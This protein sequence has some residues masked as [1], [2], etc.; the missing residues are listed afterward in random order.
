MN[1]VILL[2][3]LNNKINIKCK[4]KTSLLS[5]LQR[6][7]GFNK[8]FTHINIQLFD[9]P[10]QLYFGWY[11]GDDLVHYYTL[12]DIDKIMLIVIS[13]IK[14]KVPIYRDDEL[15]CSTSIYVDNKLA[16]MNEYVL[17]Y[18]CVGMEIPLRIYDREFLKKFQSEGKYL[19]SITFSNVGE[20]YWYNLIDDNQ[21]NDEYKILR[22][23]FMEYLKSI[24]CNIYNT[25]GEL[26]VHKSA[27]SIQN[28]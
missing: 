26:L 5:C 9:T 27:L 16:N 14:R 25:K 19:R 11:K 4:D 7:Q 3:L 28:M 6:E 21:Y 17:Y 22:G 15:L 20:D 24:N 2:K 1:S 8:E 12:N 10:K 18:I 13:I 23:E